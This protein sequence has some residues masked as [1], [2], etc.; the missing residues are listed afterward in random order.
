MKDLRTGVETGKVDDVLD[1]ELDGFIQPVP[2]RGQAH[3]PGGR[4]L[5]PGLSPAVVAV[6]RWAGAPGRSARW[7][8]PPSPALPGGGRRTRPADARWWPTWPA[9]RPPPRPV[10]AS[11][12]RRGRGAPAP[13]SHRRRH[14]GGDEDAAR[15]DA[16][17]RPHVE[18][19]L[20]HQADRDL[21]PGVGGGGR[22]RSSTSSSSMSDMRSAA[23]RGR[24][25]GGGSSAS[26]REGGTID[27]A[28]GGSGGRWRS[29]GRR[30]D[31]RPRPGSGFASGRW[32]GEAGR[33]R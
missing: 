30:R 26:A 7:R 1:G 16:P 6:G 15:V 2:A 3:R 29:G 11:A 25:A 10:R 22:R 17:G 4:R 9:G 14:G 33:G 8:R 31:G 23:G 32:P 18:V 13:C 28:R 5:V 20:R 24:R 12:R 27:G 19:V 21:D